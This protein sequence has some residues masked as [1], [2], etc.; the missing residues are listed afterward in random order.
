MNTD[1][2]GY[3]QNVCAV[4]RRTSDNAVLLFHRKGYSPDKG[5][6][7]PQGGVD[8]HKDLIDEL[9]R[10]LREEIGTDKVS[11]VS[12]SPE[13]YAYDFPPGVNRSRRYRGQ[14]QR[15]ILLELCVGEDAIH[16]DHQPAEFDA[17]EWSSVQQSI[18]RV[19]SFKKDVYRRALKDLGLWK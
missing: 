3:R 1:S 8:P 9:K 14:R 18:D 10:E 2:R 17:C 5:W 7:F 19:V 12:I 16:F 6:Q 4:I 15:W 11:V 13:T